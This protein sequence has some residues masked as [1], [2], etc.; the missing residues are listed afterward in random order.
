MINLFSILGLWVGLQAFA[1]GNVPD[2]TPN[3]TDLETRARVFYAF[4]S[5]SLF[6]EIQAT[7]QSENRKYRS[8]MLGP[9][10]RWFDHL[11]TGIFFQR[12]YGF[13]HNDDWFK[14]PQ[15]AIW[16]WRNT[17]TR[18][19]D[20]LVLDVSPKVQLDFLPGEHWTFEFKTRLS[21]N[22]FNQEKLLRLRPNLSYFWI[23]S[24]VPFLSIFLQAEFVVPLLDL[25]SPNE[26][27]AYLGTLYHLSQAIQLGCYAALKW[28][29]WRNTSAYTAL[30]GK[31]YEVEANSTVIGLLGVF[32]F[33]QNE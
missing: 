27:W 3:S 14:E 16:Q 33:G 25:K 23:R 17:N 12:Q 6:S 19:E 21:H 30:T 2:N 4:D 26:R 20:L 10:Y 32:H 8:I 31:T 7:G 11:R 5:W 9:Y 1:A 22:F 28:E 18:A 24:D 29:G 13:R 15:T